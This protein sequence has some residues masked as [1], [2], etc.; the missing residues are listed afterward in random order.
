M[1]RSDFSGKGEYPVSTIVLK[2][3]NGSGAV[4]V[5]T[6]IVKLISPEHYSNRGLA[7]L[8]ASTL[9][10]SCWFSK[11]LNGQHGYNTLRYTGSMKT[12]KHSS[13][14]MSQT[15][16]LTHCFYILRVFPAQCLNWDC[17]RH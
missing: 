15:L 4:L 6:M 11:A 14:S 8:E 3:E 12:S 7:N 10:K 2:R 1:Y 9:L 16:K 5:D 13:F 17:E